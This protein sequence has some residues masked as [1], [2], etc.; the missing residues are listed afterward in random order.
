VLS[1]SNLATFQAWWLSLW[2]Q[3]LALLYFLNHAGEYRNR[4]TAEW[5]GNA[6]KVPWA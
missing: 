6:E 3:E 2:Y 5:V 4:I 1:A